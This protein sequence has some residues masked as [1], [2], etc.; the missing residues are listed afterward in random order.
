[1]CFKC[2]QYVYFYIQIDEDELEDA[3]WF[4]REEVVQML[5]G[6]H[7]I[8]LFCPPEQAI[9]HILIRAWVNMSS[10]L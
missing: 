6:K 9:A 10:N 4:T 2:Y 5:T 3:R 7:A 8:N 1:M